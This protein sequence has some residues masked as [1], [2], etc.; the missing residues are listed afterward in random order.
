MRLPAYKPTGN[1]STDIANA[2]HP[3]RPLSH[4][5]A[6][7]GHHPSA[8]LYGFPFRRELLQ[9]RGREHDDCFGHPLEVFRYRAVSD[10]DAELG[11]ILNINLSSTYNLT[12]STPHFRPR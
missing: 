8:L 11:C 9:E 6:D 7:I 1:P 5:A 2:N 3:D 10:D 12:A 4:H